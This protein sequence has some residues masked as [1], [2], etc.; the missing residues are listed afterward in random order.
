MTWDD[1]LDEYRALGGIA[2]NVRL[3]EG[4][5]GRGVFP[6]DPH[7]PAVLHTPPRL[8]FPARDVIVR[9]G[10]L[11]LR[12]QGAGERERAFFENYH[13]Y[14][15]WGA[16][17]FEASREQQARWHALPQELITAIQSISGTGTLVNRFAAPTTDVCLNTY[18]QSRVFDVNGTLCALP[19]IDLVNHASDAPTF[20]IEDGVGVHGSFAGEMLVSYN[21][22]DP[23]GMAM[24]YGFSSPSAIAYSTRIQLNLDAHRKL[25]VMRDIKVTVNENRMAFPAVETN[26]DTVTLAFLVLGFSQAPELPRTVFRKLVQKYVALEEADRA[27]DAIAHFNRSR[28]I[29]LLRK[30]RGHE[31][32][33]VRVLEDA[34][35]NQLDALSAYIGARATE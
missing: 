10:V 3:G 23:W 26:D 11:T 24:S 17:G 25:T 6:V 27:F 34:V 13:R 30:L 2:E 4:A 16:G 19:M 22:N 5:L 14:F 18:I 29:A 12:T 32:P 7:K 33:L 1:L 15:G 35:I 28:F 20:R 9:D 8:Q 31:G 21:L